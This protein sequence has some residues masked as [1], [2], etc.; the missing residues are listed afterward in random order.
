MFSETGA[1]VGF[2]DSFAQ[3][4]TQRHCQ[5]GNFQVLGL[6]LGVHYKLPSNYTFCA[7]F[8]VGRHQINLRETNSLFQ[9]DSWKMGL[10]FDWVSAQ[11][12]KQGLENYETQALFL[13]LPLT[14][15][16]ILRKLFICSMSFVSPSGKATLGTYVELSC[17]LFTVHFDTCIQKAFWKWKL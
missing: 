5:S 4:C 7:S 17:L 13:T 6:G 9:Y 11:W 8:I 2:N 10:A 12:L 15:C 3:G 16:T 14:D 1:W